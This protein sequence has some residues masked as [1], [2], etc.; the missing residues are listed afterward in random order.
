M[1]LVHATEQRN[2]V[3][4]DNQC[5]RQSPMQVRECEHLQESDSGGVDGAFRGGRHRQ[6]RELGIERVECSNLLVAIEQRRGHDRRPAHVQ[7]EAVRWQ[8]SGKAGMESRS[9]R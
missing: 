3:N 7:R 5:H 6:G 8:M 1:A 4:Q 9:V 2:Q